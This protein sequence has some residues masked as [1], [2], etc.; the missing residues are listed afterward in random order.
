MANNTSNTKVAIIADSISNDIRLTTLQLTYPRFIH[1]ELLTHR[2]FSRNS[3]SSRA[4]PIERI[5]GQVESTPALPIHWGRN[6]P[7]MQAREELEPAGRIEAQ[8]LW[9]QSIANQVKIVKQLQ[10]LGLHKQVAN[11]LLEP[12]QYMH[13]IVTATE[14]DNFFNLRIHKDADPNIYE[15]AASIYQALKLSV[16]KELKIGQLHLP[17]ITISDF[18]KFDYPELLKIATARCARVSYLNHD[19]TSPDVTKDLELCN[20]LVSSGHFSPL[21]HSATPMEYPKNTTYP[22]NWQDGVTHLDSNNNFWSGNLRG[23]VSYRH[24]INQVCKHTE[25]I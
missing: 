20:K 15:L 10:N 4:I 17:Y 5:I 8:H 3:S 9:F 6:I 21:E 14:W 7:G 24:C 23:W 19:N 13:T 12:Y 25:S 22:I 16:P 11:R 2:V 18:A 1:S